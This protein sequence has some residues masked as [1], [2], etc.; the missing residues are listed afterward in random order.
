[1]QDLTGKRIKVTTSS[2]CYYAVVQSVEQESWTVALEEE[3]CFKVIPADGIEQGIVQI[4]DGVN[5][6][7]FPVIEGSQ[8]LFH[9]L[10]IKAT[11]VIGDLVICGS[12]LGQITLAA[13]CFARLTLI[14]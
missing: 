4:V 12:R 7:N 14:G 3:T 13:A 8:W 5:G 1:M 2:D 11:S 9:G 10:E 6:A